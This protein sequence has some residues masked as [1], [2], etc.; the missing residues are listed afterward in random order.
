MSVIV[1]QYIMDPNK[2]DILKEAIVMDNDFDES[3]VYLSVDLDMI[4]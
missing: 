3:H 2:Q 1:W 4:A